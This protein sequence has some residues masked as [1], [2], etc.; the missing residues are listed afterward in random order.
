MILR[1]RVVVS[2]GIADPVGGPGPLAVWMS[3]LLSGTRD[4][5]GPVPERE[6]DPELLVQCGGAG[7]QG[8][9]CS[10]P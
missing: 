9:S 2:T 4:D 6:A 1:R 5:T 8:S 7:P 10:A 3:S